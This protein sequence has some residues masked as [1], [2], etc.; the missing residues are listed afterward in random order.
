MIAALL[1]LQYGARA[2]FALCD[3]MD[4]VHVDA[5]IRFEDGIS[6]SYD[7]DIVV[8]IFNNT[9]TN[10]AYPQAKLLNTTPLPPGMS[11]YTTNWQVFASA[12][13]TGDTGWA[14]IGYHV[15]TAISANYTVK[16]NLLLT[17]F[18]PLSVDSCIFSD[19]LT[20]N[21]RPVG[22]S[23]VNTVVSGKTQMS[24]YPN[25]ATD[26]VYVDN[27]Q[28][29]TVIDI[30]SVTGGCLRR[31]V[32]QKTSARIDIADL[33]PGIYIVTETGSSN[34]RKLIKTR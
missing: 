1:L 13:N 22:T 21:L 28:A 19:T 7:S 5:G 31:V 10:F 25:P 33:P 29:G 6:T 15:T 17:N 3:T 34:T 30:S 32:T 2:Q 4:I 24:I 16:F 23:A 9:G 27:V 8:P 18:A 20:I 26:I 14:H 11:L 12:W